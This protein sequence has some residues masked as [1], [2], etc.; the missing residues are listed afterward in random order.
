MGI[1]DMGR[2]FGEGGCGVEW[3][4]NRFLF[5]IFNL[6]WGGE[7]G[8]GQWNQSCEIIKKKDE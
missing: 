5:S 4:E 6:L 2:G 3:N 8:G 1:H 7:G